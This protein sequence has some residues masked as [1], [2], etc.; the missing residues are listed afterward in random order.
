[1]GLQW[2]APG[3]SELEGLLSSSGSLMTKRLRSH[4][5]LMRLESQYMVATLIL[6]IGVCVMFMVKIGCAKP[7]YWHTVI[8][9]QNYYTHAAT[10]ISYARYK[11][12]H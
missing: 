11:V 5:R 6:L 9:P 8:S 12:R 3:P 7:A 2:L 4:R 10:A 1:M